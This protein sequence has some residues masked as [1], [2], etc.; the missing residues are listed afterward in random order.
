VQRLQTRA[1]FQA[2]LAGRT[3]A[4]TRHFALHCVALPAPEAIPP[5]NAG[6]TA[7]SLNT[8]P[9]KPLFAGNDGWLGSMT[10][11]RWA[12]RA[13]T[14]NAIK[15]QIYQVSTDLTFQPPL[16]AYVVRLAAGF[17][18]AVFPSATSPA[19]KAA[20]RQELVQLFEKAG[21]ASP[22]SATA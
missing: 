8:G 9:G 14:R 19:L 4:R 3:V 12:K 13:V 10:P 15:R 6:R 18:K 11:K 7:S 21:L 2:V 20:V 16:A 5:T 17:D 22:R 1:Q